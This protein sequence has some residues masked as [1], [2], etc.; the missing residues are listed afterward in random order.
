MSGKLR[1][2]FLFAQ[3]CQLIQDI[4]HLFLGFCQRQ[5]A[6]YQG[7]ELCEMIRDEWQRPKG[8]EQVFL[9]HQRAESTEPQDPR[10][11]VP[12][13]VSRF[14]VLLAPIDNVE[15]KACSK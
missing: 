15:D 2:R 7:A 10:N 9:S 5:A 13:V 14:V 6:G 11:T 8:P 3:C 12:T 1:L 4:P